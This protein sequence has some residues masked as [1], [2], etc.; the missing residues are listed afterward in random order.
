MV[1]E[2]ND[3]EGRIAEKLLEVEPGGECVIYFD[4]GGGSPY[5]GL[6][7]MSLIRFRGLEATG[8]VLGECSSAALWPF[9]ACQRR[10]VFPHS[11][12]LFHR[13]RWQSGE[14][15]ELHEAAE[16]AKHFGTLEEEMDDLL[17][18]LF[19]VSRDLVDSWNRPGRYLTGRDLA[20]AGVAELA[21]VFNGVIPASIAPARDGSHRAGKGR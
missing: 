9:A 7:L 21:D 13:I 8:V 14:H 18:Q 11:M 16:W 5:V 4:S 3:D 19:G 12:F 1:G 15:V 10:L 17:A 2:L 20:D 6:S